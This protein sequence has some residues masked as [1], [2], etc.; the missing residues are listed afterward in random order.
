MSVRTQ[1]IAALS[2]ATRQPKATWERTTGALG[3]ANFTPKG[4]PGGGVGSAHYLQGPLASVLMSTAAVIPS[5]APDI[6]RCLERLVTRM[7][8]GIR[9]PANALVTLPHPEIVAAGTTLRAYIEQQII[10]W[11][12]PDTVMLDLL[13]QDDARWSAWSLEL[14]P[15]VPSARLR[16]HREDE[17]WISALFT[18]SSK[19]ENA[20][21]APVRRKVELS[22]PILKIA[23]DLLADT[24][25]Q[26]SNPFFSTPE[27]NPTGGGNVAPGNETAAPDPAMDQNA[28]AISDQPAS[29]ELD[30][31]QQSN[32]S[33]EREK[34]QPPSESRAGRS[35]KFQ[36]SDSHA[37]H[38][39]APAG[40]AA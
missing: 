34:S 24:L 3:N 23:G 20:E 33:G 32:P 29:T 39:Y 21:W 7:P 18:L 9:D 14:E 12:A 40:A 11:S 28:A 30:G 19:S 27:T 8:A 36:R 35:R 13:A 15:G 10:A 5:E 37:R 25:A 31:R 6:V 16:I 38:G 17:G 2:Q 22:L 1:V 26:Q 4:K